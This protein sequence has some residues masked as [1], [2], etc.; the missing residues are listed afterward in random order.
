MQMKV[1]MVQSG[2]V[3]QKNTFVALP[4]LGFGVYDVVAH[5]NIRMKIILFLWYKEFKKLN[6]KRANVV[7]Q[8]VSWKNKLRRQILRGKKMS[9]YDK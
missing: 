7:N 1:L 6:L 8:Q 2:N 5:C 4:N 9:K 3:L